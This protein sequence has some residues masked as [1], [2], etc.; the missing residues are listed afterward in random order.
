[1]GD[2]K[3]PSQLWNDKK[4]KER[5]WSTGIDDPSEKAVALLEKQNLITSSDTPI[6]PGMEEL[7]EKVCAADN[8]CD[9]MKMALRRVV[10][11]EP[12]RM[13]A[14]AEGY[15]DWKN[16]WKLSRHFGIAAANKS[17]LV[18]GSKRIAMLAQEEMER[19]LTDE[20]DTLSP[21]DVAITGAIYLDKVANAE[22]WN[23][24]NASSGDFVS[25]LTRIADKFESGGSVKL[26][27]SVTPN[28]NDVID[29]T[30]RDASDG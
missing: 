9:R 5:G 2:K 29:V 23:R 16:L 28:D 13:A 10:C 25:E 6:P 1:M 19:R 30:P 17:Q 11:G 14:A 22:G 27:L 4:K 15:A 24:A 8:V 12:Y 26:E 7:W 18:D 21:R 3:N 20:A